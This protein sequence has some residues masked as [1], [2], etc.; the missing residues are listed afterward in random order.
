MA[1][2]LKY[3]NIRLTTPGEAIQN[4]I[5]SIGMTQAE[6]ADRM[7]LPKAEILDIIKSK[8]P[9][10]MDIAF[11]LENALDIPATFWLRK[12]SR[13][14]FKSKEYEQR[15]KQKLQ[16][17]W[18]YLFP[19]KQL[20]EFGYLPRIKKRYKLI[21]DLYAFFDIKSEKQWEEIYL[22]KSEKPKSSSSLSVADMKS[23][24]SASAWLRIGEI[25]AT[26]LEV[27]DF[28]S[29]KFSAAL[30]TIKELAYSMPHDFAE[31]LKVICADCGV[32]LVFTPYLT[33]VSFSGTVRWLR[34]TPMIQISRKRKSE[35]IFWTL[36]FRLA[37]H[38]LLRGR[39]DLFLEQF[40]EKTI[41]K[42]KVD[43]IN[44]Y[45]FNIQLPEEQLNEIKQIKTIEP[46]S[47]VAF[48]E[49]FRIPA[50]FIAFRLQLLELIKRHECNQLKTKIVQLPEEIK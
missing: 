39:K 30:A 4:Y 5:D 32:A 19:L 35:H 22:A 17:N 3:E 46:E 42:E 13:Y 20:K 28:D 38:I 21:N 34:D 25:Q 27:N 6:L 11:R 15:K 45:A 49:N 48:S 2:F 8:I 44:A 12:E 29:E 24:H 16:R 43:E 10:S 26:A 1:R 31:Q 47:I 50:S 18:M 33:N 37:A 14:H 36:F 40:D 9:M 7:G 41:S 23:P